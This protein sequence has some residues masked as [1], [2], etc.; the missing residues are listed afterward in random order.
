MLQS[1]A[2]RAGSEDPIAL[3]DSDD[4]NAGLEAEKVTPV[5]GLKATG[6][7]NYTEEE[8]R[9]VHLPQ[10]AVRL[11]AQDNILWM[12]WNGERPLGP[13]ALERIRQRHV[14]A[15]YSR[16]KEAIKWR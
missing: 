10:C 12:I 13:K 6:G 4:G 9:A 5:E 7:N 16:T 1:A 2:G 3:K 15:G 8:V 11:P 14:Q